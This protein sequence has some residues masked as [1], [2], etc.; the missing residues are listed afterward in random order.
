MLFFAN[1][2]GKAGF[3]LFE[4]KR[5]G[6]QNT[7]T[8]SCAGNFRNAEKLLGIERFALFQLRTSAIGKTEAAPSAALLRDAIWIGKAQNVACIL[9]VGAL[10]RLPANQLHPALRLCA[11]FLTPLALVLHQPAQT[12]A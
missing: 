8:G 1:V 4:G 2:R 6:Q 10:R 11:G 3:Q 5:S 9:K 12:I 7:R